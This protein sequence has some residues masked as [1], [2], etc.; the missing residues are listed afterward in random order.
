[1]INEKFLGVVTGIKADVESVTE[2]DG[3]KCKLPIYSFKIESA[4][5]DYESINKF[6]PAI[7]TVMLAIQ[8]MPFT[9]IKF[10]EQS[11]QKLSLNVWATTDE[12]NNLPAIES[13]ASYANVKITDL[14]VAVKENIP[15]YVFSFSMLMSENNANFL[16]KAVKQKIEFEL[17]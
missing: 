12:Q 3:T 16:F 7:S 1:M 9:S 8:P 2:P 15:T 11:A 17:S 14:S 4:D 13:D 6:N 5:I 10:G